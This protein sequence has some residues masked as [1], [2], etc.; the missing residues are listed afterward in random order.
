MQYNDSTG[1]YYKNSIVEL[2]KL[3]Y[4]VYNI[5]SGYVYENGLVGSIKNK[6]SSIGIIFHDVD[7]NNLLSDEDYMFI[8]L[9]NINNGNYPHSGDA[10][11]FRYSNAIMAGEQDIVKLP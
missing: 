2:S 11:V 10:V 1:K 7:D 3:L 4:A 8:P 6:T 9:K 5:T